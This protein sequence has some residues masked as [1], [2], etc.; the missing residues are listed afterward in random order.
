MA[1]ISTNKSNFTAGEISPR[2]LGRGDL[3]AYENGA[4]TLTNVFIHPTGGLSRRAGLRFLDMARGDGR[5]VGFEFNANQ[6]YLLIFSDLHVDV[7]RDDV[8]VADFVS[9]WSLAQV[10]GINWTQSA[11]TLLVV[12]PDVAPKKITRTSD[13]AWTV[14]D[15]TFHATDVRIHQP[16]HKFSDDD[17]TLTPSATSGAITL[18][19]SADVF[20]ATHVG[21]RFRIVDK[22]IEI[23]SVTS[24][25]VAAATVKE[26]LSATAATKDWEEQAFSSFRGWP[27]SVC[28][29]QDRMVIGGSRDLP[30]RLWL[31]KSADLFNFD[32]GGGLD[33]ESIEFAILSDQVNAVRAVFSG[34]HLQV[35]T[36]GA[37]WMV[38]GSPLT[39]ANIQL[40]RQTQIGSPTDRTVP[41]RNVDGATLFV[42][43]NGAELR[44]F[45][46]T[47]VEQAYQSADLGMLAHHLLAK[48]LDQDFDKSQRLFHMVLA[49]GKLATVTIY[50][51]EQVTAWTVQET[52]GLFRS[53]VVVGEKT[54]VLIQR[55]SQFNIEVFD[56]TLNVDSGLS[57][58]DAS[59]KTTW[60]GLA[61]LEGK[62]VKVLA[63]GAVHA[64]TVVS[65]GAVTLEQAVSQV[66][67][68]LGFTHVVEPLPP[69]SSS[70]GIGKSGGPVRPVAITFRLH[71]TAAL[72]L[73]TGRGFQEI[74]FKRFGVSV[75]DNQPQP[76]SGDRTIRAFG[77]RK[78]STKPLWCI[79]QDTPLNFSLLSISTELSING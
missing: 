50:R 14:T 6:I 10:A 22:E 73:D 31:S 72:R 36:S 59:P 65:G 7:Y 60:S 9:P 34:R 13:A 47:D 29:H 68:G 54:Y 30:N 45:L 40:N 39:P 23:T 55:D 53:V 79:E 52:Q 58:T 51:A 75:L 56:D 76:F 1:R 15:W 19:A 77:W 2:L 8:K 24:A 66:E 64:D 32:L 17:V 26:T 70:G 74:P 21:G 67:I 35:F 57:G 38:T 11:D 37:E 41:P 43:R 48:T 27:V 28:F 46:F 44:E 3:R 18:T 20:D 49:T 12:H 63:D 42:P 16:H 25:T 4:S 33:D 71:E 69:T 61:H 78:D 5:L 62:T